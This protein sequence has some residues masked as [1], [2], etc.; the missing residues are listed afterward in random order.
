MS[1]IAGS[2]IEL[3]GNTPML[4]L[5]NY[6]RLNQVKAR[7][8]AKLEY[9]NPGG[10]SKDRIGYAMIKDAEDRGILKEGSVI[11]E[12]T[13]GNTG[14]GLALVA[15]SRGY[16]LILTMP[17]TM[18]L[19]RRKLLQA[20]GA[21]LV[22]TPGEAGMNGAVIKA[23]QLAA[24]IPDS[25]IPQQ[26]KNPANPAIHRQTTAE[27]I[28][29]DTDG[30][31]DIFIAGVGSAG[32]I[33]GVGEALKAKNPEIQIVAMEPFDSPVLSGGQAGA[34]GI[35]GIG[36]N[37]VPAIYNAQVVDEIFKVKTDAA[38]KTAQA[39]AKTE[40]L[41]VGIS[42]GAAAFAATEIARRP[43]N[44]GKNIVVLLP[45]SGERYLSTPLFQG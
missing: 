5:V 15:A 19:E 27:E 42:S 36:T 13:S 17:E 23:E 39:L 38:Y 20:L 21:E 43:E 29:R 40:G 10:S 30:R 2:L 44:E 14:V 45:D 26:F 3:I 28:W 33:S 41:L 24:D 32:T 8:I 16:R 7:I 22:L 1:R 35:Q 34:H 4:E 18:S 25:F 6:N 12:P 9:F 31:V 37:F 11:I